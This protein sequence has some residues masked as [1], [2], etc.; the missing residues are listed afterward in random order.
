M[1]NRK[2]F[3]ES[4]GGTCQNW[5]W[6]WS[7]VN[8]AEKFVIFGLWDIHTDGLILNSNWKGPGRK[9]SLE[10]VRLISEE[11]YKLKVFPMRYDRTEEGKPMIK[12]FDP[13][14]IDKV[15]ASNES[16]CWYAVDGA[17]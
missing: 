2:K 5:N 10:H 1:K 13:V 4:V 12:S 16:G 14:L 11:G 9:Q 8:H 7:F 6:S 3:I 15:L 17:S